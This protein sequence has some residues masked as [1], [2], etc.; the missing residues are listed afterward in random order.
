ML[1]HRFCGTRACSCTFASHEKS[2]YLHPIKNGDFDPETVAMGS[3]RILWF[4]CN[5]CKHDFQMSLNSVKSNHWCSYCD[6]NWHHCEDNDCNYCNNKSFMSHEK[7]KFWHPTKNGTLT[8]KDV[9]PSSNKK[10]WF[11]CE[12]CNHDFIKILNNIGARGWCKYCTHNWEHCGNEECKYCYNKSFKSHEKAKFWHLTKNKISALFVAKSS[13]KKRW[14]NCNECGHELYMSPNDIYND[15]WCRYCTTRWIHCGDSNCNFCF[16]RSIA[17]HEN[18]KYFN[19][20]KNTIDVLKVAKTSGK[21]YWFDCNKCNHSF[22]ARPADILLGHWCGYCSLSWKHCGKEECDYC[23]NRSFKSHYRSIF[24]NKVKNQNQNPLYIIKSKNKKYWFTCEDC[25]NDFFSS[26]NSIVSKDSWCK[27]CKNKT[28]K[29]LYDWLKTNLKYEIEY[30]KRFMWCINEKSQKIMPLDFVIEKLK[31]IIELDGDQ[32]FKQISNW[33][34]P[35]ENQKR[36]KLKMNYSIKN[37][38]KIIRIYQQD[39]WDDKNNW[40]QEL[41]N[42]IENTDVITCIKS[43]KQYVNDVYK[44]YEDLFISKTEVRE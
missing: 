22:Q 29:K 7:S 35:V 28:E 41:N 39:V 36:D 32:H 11:H 17:S 9:L 25:E 16:N 10:Y 3:S 8:P 18:G 1:N 14:F 21:K 26:L 34:C 24:F 43:T 27:Y 15:S 6:N 42:S 33:M 20:D 5:D 38:Y 12:E 4:K 13:G 40:E 23:Y 44:I 19:K 37:G 2:K 31:I 30:Q